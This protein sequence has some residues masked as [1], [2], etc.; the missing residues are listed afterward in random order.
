MIENE[1]MRMTENEEVRMIEKRNEDDREEEG[2]EMVT[3]HVV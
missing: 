2:K 3:V 1:E